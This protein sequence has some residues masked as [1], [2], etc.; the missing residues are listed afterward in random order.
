MSETCSKRGNPMLVDPVFLMK[1]RSS[2]PF[3]KSHGRTKNF[4]SL[5]SLQHHFGLVHG[6]D[7]YCKKVTSDLENLIRLGVLKT[8]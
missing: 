5:F 3:C 1:I 7:V 8:W 4:S 6:N 2:C